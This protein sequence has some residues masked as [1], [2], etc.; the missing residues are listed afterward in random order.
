[1]TIKKGD[2]APDFTL[3]DTN[4]KAR[5]LKEFSGKK[6]VLVFY[7]GAFT[8]VCT[9]ELCTFRD[10]LAAFNS[11]DATVIAI[12]VDGPFANQAFA[13]QNGLKFPVLSDYSRSV[14]KAYGGVHEDFVG[15]T[16]YSVS[17]RAVF[18]VDE[19]G[20]I[21]YAW[22]SE[23]PGIEPDYAAIKQVLS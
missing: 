10:S 21:A 13:E 8:S 16:G 3:F 17:M 11:L 20:K 15:L 2:Q 9:K 22:V 4:R 5:S 12:S 6:V 14:S 1:M 23:N 19:H 18:V 7:P